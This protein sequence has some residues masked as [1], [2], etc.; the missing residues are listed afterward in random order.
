MINFLPGFLSWV[1]RF[2]LYADDCGATVERENAAQV[3]FDW[4]I[5]A[6][7]KVTARQYCLCGA[8]YILSNA[9]IENL[10][11]SARERAASFGKQKRALEK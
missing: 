5:R 7:A 6:G 1:L 8:K 2:G 11:A 10:R 4:F 3:V 9:G